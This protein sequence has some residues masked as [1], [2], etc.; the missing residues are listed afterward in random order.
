MVQAPVQIEKNALKKAPQEGKALSAL[1][2]KSKAELFQ[3]ISDQNDLHGGWQKNVEERYQGKV[4][5]FIKRG[6]ERKIA[7]E[8][9]SKQIQKVWAKVFKDKLATPGT[10]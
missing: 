9:A 7:E 6:T 2:E 10:K 1:K 8:L 5:K 4:E 3:A